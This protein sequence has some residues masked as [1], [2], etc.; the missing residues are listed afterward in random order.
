MSG[1]GSN[2]SKDECSE[3]DSEEVKEAQKEKGKAEAKPKADAKH[4]IECA[5]C[6][7]SADSPFGLVC[8][9]QL[10]TVLKYQKEQ[11][12]KADLGAHTTLTTEET[13]TSSRSSLPSAA[14]TPTAS[15]YAS[16]TFSDADSFSRDGVLDRFAN[17]FTNGCSRA[18]H[19][20]IHAGH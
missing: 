17:D 9:A 7:G 3:G 15:D 4:D 20:G 16:S 18:V 8:F 10:T 11:T 13:C 12:E 19:I 14:S 5:L 1:S 2:N 6:R